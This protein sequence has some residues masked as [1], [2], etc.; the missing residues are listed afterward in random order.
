MVFL[1]YCTGDVFLGG[2]EQTYPVPPAG[3]GGEAGEITVNHFGYANTTA[4]LDWVYANYN[5]PSQ[6]V[7][8]GSSAGALGSS[9][10]TGVV[11]ER[12]PETPIIHIGDGAGGYRSDSVS[13]VLNAWR[14]AEILPDWG[15]F[16][17]A[18]P[19][20]LTLDV[21]LQA[22]A[23]FENVTLALYNTAEDETQYGFL[24]LLGES[25][26]TLLDNLLANTA[27]V[28]FATGDIPTYIA[29]G[30]LHTILRFPEF[31]TYSVNDVSVRDWV[32]GLIRGEAVSDV[33]CDAESGACQVA[34]V[35]G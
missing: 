16:A 19:T 2:G 15:V 10:Y 8:A 5:N 26:V 33:Q 6:V 31:Y 22:S 18:D 17:D 29:G 9:L 35:E 24:Q 28:E 12:Y 21:F 14:V 3:E 27:D 30:S 25:N 23:T 11:A 1:P 20:A 34:P 7:V 4:V 32:A 13:E